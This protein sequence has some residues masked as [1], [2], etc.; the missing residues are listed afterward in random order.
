MQSNF[1]AVTPWFLVVFCIIRAFRK[2]WKCRLIHRFSYRHIGE[3]I[4]DTD[5]ATLVKIPLIVCT[6]VFIV[7]VHGNKCF[8][9]LEWQWQVGIAAVFL[10]WA[11]V[12]LYMRKLRL[13]GK[14]VDE[15]YTGVQDLDPCNITKKIYLICFKNS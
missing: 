8:C 15:Y 7:G 6:I 9:P 14:L 10:A 4:D 12:V 5:L 3:Y 1:L 2:V 13:L 11:D